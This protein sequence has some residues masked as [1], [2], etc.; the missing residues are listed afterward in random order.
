MIIPCAAVAAPAGKIF[1]EGTDDSQDI[2]KALAGKFEQLY[3]GASVI[4]PDS[5]GS[6]GGIRRVREGKTDLGRTSRPLDQNEMKYGLTYLVFA[7][8]PVVFFSNDIDVEGLTYE[9]ITGIYSGRISNWSQLGGEERKIYHVGREAG[10]SSRRV[11]GRYIPG[12]KETAGG[13][14]I[15][16]TN[17]E[18]INAVKNHK[19]TIGYGPMSAVIK[20]GLK[21]TRVNGVYPSPENASKGSYELTAPFGVVYMKNNLIPLAEA[22]VNFLYSAEGRRTIREYGCYPVGR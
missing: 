9:Q 3:P 14:K 15:Y 12:F 1:V 11:L 2:M 6:S 18:T 7:K 5:I 20:T 8:A 21:V 19:S 22:F 10:D 16:Y 13:G 17:S 4:V